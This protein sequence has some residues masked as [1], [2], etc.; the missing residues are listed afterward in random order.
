MQSHQIWRWL[1]LKVGDGRKKTS[2]RWVDSL[3][4]SLASWSR[5][6]WPWLSHYHDLDLSKLHLSYSEQGGM[7]PP[8]LGT[9]GSSLQW[10]TPD[11]Q[12]KLQGSSVLHRGGTHKAFPPPDVQSLH[13]SFLAT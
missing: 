11:T 3:V 4:G 1:W 12:V 9:M 8:H 7:L 6:A 10:G 5:T 13:L 2:G